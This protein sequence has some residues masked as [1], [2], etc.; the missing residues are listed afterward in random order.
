MA[1][2]YQIIVKGNSLG[3]REG[4]LAL[5]NLTLIST[6]DG[7]ILFDTG[8]YSNRSQL[9][10]GLSKRGLTPADVD[11]VFLS[12]LHFDH[13]HNID[14][15]PEST[16]YV[17]QKEWEYARRP[18]ERDIF[19]PWLIHQQLRTHDLRLVEGEGAL[20]DGVTYF[21]APGHTPGSYV[22]AIDSDTKGRVILAGDAIKYLK[23]AI[24]KQSDLLF[25]VS[26]DSAETIERILREGDR[27]VPGHYPELIKGDE[28][29]VP[30]EDAEITL[31]VR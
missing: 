31:V 24:V 19:I 9:L 18:H 29:F 3:M 27:I 10:A 5:A 6:P 7:L 14:L 30:H 16:V 25:G 12:H 11:K 20:A 26:G 17:S 2:D 4:F 15:F 1:V 22:V 8:H 23:E 13:C 28:G 21:P